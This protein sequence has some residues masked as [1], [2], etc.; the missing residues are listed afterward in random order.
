MLDVRLEFGLQTI[1]QNEG[2]AVNRKN[3]MK[4]VQENIIKVSDAGIEHEV[5]VIYGLPEQTLTS[6]IKTIQWCLFM[7]IPVIKAFPLMLLRGTD[8]E[9]KKQKW[10]LVESK[11]SMPVVI[12][13]DTFSHEDWLSMSRISQS[14]KDT[15]NNHPLLLEDLLK[16]CDESKIQFDRFQPFAKAV[17]SPVTIEA[18]SY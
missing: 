6:F 13:S 3:N 18:E 10:G 14:L 7:K 15:E 16:L 1:H 5:S 11:D 2:V 9:K 17:L 8:T 4:R 12:K